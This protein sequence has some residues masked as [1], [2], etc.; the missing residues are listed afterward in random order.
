MPR[1]K[2]ASITLFYLL[3]YLITYIVNLFLVL[4]LEIPYILLSLLLTHILLL[5][6]IYLIIYV[7]L[8]QSN[9]N[10][11]ISSFGIRKHNLV[12]SF[13]WAAAFSTPIPLLWLIGTQIVGVDTI[14]IA[15]KPSWANPPIL[16]QVLISSI[17]LWIL[18]GIVAFLF[19]EAFSYEF[20]KE[21]PKKIVIPLIASLW[22]GLYNNTTLLTGNFDPFDVIFFG[23]FCIGLS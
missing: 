7:V 18:T 21:F 4:H 11:T 1:E 19:W 15:A 14:L 23:F 8:K 5:V 17:L 16:P 3:T 10:C 12:N 6:G 9:E 20:M 13:L 2:I 22:A